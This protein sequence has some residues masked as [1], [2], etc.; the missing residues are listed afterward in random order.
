MPARTDPRLDRIRA[1]AEAYARGDRTDPESKDAARR[2]PDLAPLLANCLGC[3][4]VAQDLLEHVGLSPFDTDL[5]FLDALVMTRDGMRR[6]LE[7]VRAGA[8]EPVAVCDWVTDAFSWQPPD[9][10]PDGVLAEIAGELMVGEEAVASLVS[11]DGAYTLLL[12]HLETTP[13]A[14]S[15]VAAVGLTIHRHHVELR[16]VF[17]GRLMD[18]IDD[19]EFR[20]EVV[21]LLADHR[22]AFPTIEDDLA[23]AAAILAGAPDPGARVDR[24]LRCL[25]RTADPLTCAETIPEEDGP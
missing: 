12:H 7:M 10:D 23:D 25:A 13:P 17:V 2:D 4:S 24:F 16:V 15:D 3:N 1:I 19:P 8:L 14:L 21:R 18:D 5:P 9:A 20:R 22:E 6:N 11:D